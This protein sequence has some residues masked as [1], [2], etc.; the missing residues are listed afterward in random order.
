MPLRVNLDLRS[1][2]FDFEDDDDGNHSGGDASSSSVSPQSQSDPENDSLI[3]SPKALVE[4]D[5]RH[6]LQAVEGLEDPSPLEYVRDSVLRFLDHPA[7]QLVGLLVVMGIL[8][9][10]AFFFFLLVGWQR[11]CDTPSK[12]DCDPRNDW[13]NFSIQMLNVFISYMNLVSFPWRCSNFFHITGLLQKCCCCP[14][15]WCCPK[16]NNAVGCGLYGIPNDPDIWFHI[17]LNKR[18]GITCF[19]LFNNVLQFVNHS[20]RI[21]YRTYDLQN[22]WPG[23]ILTSV[24][25]LSSFSCA[26]CGASWMFYETGKIRKAHPEFG[27]GPI[28]MIKQKFA[29]YKASSGG[30]NNST[31]SSD[32]AKRKPLNKSSNH[33]NKDHQSDDELGLPPRPVLVEEEEDEDEDPSEFQNERVDDLATCADALNGNVS[34]SSY[35]ETDEDADGLRR[36]ARSTS[37]TTGS[38]SMS[39]APRRRSQTLAGTDVDMEM[40]TNDTLQDTLHSQVSRFSDEDQKPQLPTLSSNGNHHHHHHHRRHQHQQHNNHAHPY[41]NNNNNEAARYPDPTRDPLHR[42]LFGE[43][44]ERGALRMFAM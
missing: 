16:R 12:Y 28:D 5:Y 2:S 13:Y 23:N 15:T 22:T 11:M 18:L 17:P 44:K 32:E 26:G 7:M 33:H 21:R 24:F 39:P 42:H 27:P 25:F 31:C 35:T 36:R 9:D 4:E 29:E 37:F 3:S 43:G 19:L 10:G 14:S 20:M 41:H 1:E 6:L 40:G 38:P 30:S 34:F 8:V